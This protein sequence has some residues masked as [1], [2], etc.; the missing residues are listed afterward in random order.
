MKGKSVLAF[1]SLLVF[2]TWGNA[3]EKV[4]VA[5]SPGSE[6]GVAVVAVRC[7][8]FSWSSIPWAVGYRLSLI[9]I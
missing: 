6:S 9:H 5:V 2:M 4:P 8:T 1:L 7:P 3:Q